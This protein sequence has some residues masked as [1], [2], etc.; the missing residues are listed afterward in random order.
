MHFFEQQTPLLLGLSL[1][2]KWA[3]AHVFSSRL[4]IYLLAAVLLQ[5]PRLKGCNLA[6]RDT[7]DN[8]LEEITVDFFCSGLR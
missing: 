7:A 2:A 1:A 6:V 8:C 4:H 3:S 5:V